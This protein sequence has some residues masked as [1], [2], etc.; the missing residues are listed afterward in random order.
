MGD[1]PYPWEATHIVAA[2]AGDVAT[3]QQE[4]DKGA[5]LNDTDHEYEQTP[6]FWAAGK[7]HE[8]AVQLLIRYGADVNFI[9]PNLG[10]TPLLAATA[11][12]HEAVAR[13]LIEAGAHVNTRDASCV[14]PLIVA[15]KDGSISLVEL[16]LNS[17]ADIDIKG[18]HHGQTALSLA[19]ANGHTDTVKFLLQKNASTD[20]VDEAGRKALAW[21]IEEGHDDIVE[22]LANHG[23][24]EGSRGADKD[25]LTS[26]T[27]FSAYPDISGGSNEDRLE[28]A[29]KQGYISVVEEIL[30][31]AVDLEHRDE[32]GRTPLMLAA[33]E[34]HIKLVKLLLEK[35][36]QVDSK[37]EEGRTP[38]SYAA[39]NGHMEVV[40]L[41]LNNGADLHSEDDQEMTPLTV[42]A[43]RGHDAIVSLLLEKGADANHWDGN[44]FS[45][46]LHAALEGHARIVSMLLERGV[47]PNTRDKGEGKSILTW[48]AS[49]GHLE[50][51]ELLLARNVSSNDEETDETPLAEA[52]DNAIDTEDYSSV[53]LLL[54][55]GA[56]PFSEVYWDNV[57]PLE[58]AVSNGLDEM[59][60]LF[61]K[62]KPASS[63][64]KQ[65]HVRKA[66]FQAVEMNRANLLDLLFQHYA[67]E[68]PNAETPLQWAKGKCCGSEEAIR[69][70]KPYFPN[71]VEH[72]NN[73]K[74]KNT[75]DHD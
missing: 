7:G 73:K 75:Q 23:V 8:D 48:A 28:W 46:L 62:V 36:V 59:V 67:P 58:V 33:S 26:E 31:Q 65:E 42:A 29:F 40:T 37:D 39:E 9:E 74:R 10:R 30:E 38:L 47:D 63:K 11:N 45:P 53:K 15:A 57:P 72:T 34:G 55:H 64:A 16:L 3:L 22:I 12:G 4:L 20:L 68:D 25:G 52:L 27:I 69:L 18:W 1:E 61:L 70:L 6:L 66:I 60:E 41:L 5:D 21:A 14:T 19:A 13:H 71:E 35:N 44:G 43:L 17:G 32:T 50:V 49:G 51:L 54:E 2:A 56:Q 24:D